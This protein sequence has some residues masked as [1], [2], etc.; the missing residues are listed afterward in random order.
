MASYIPERSRSKWNISYQ[1]PQVADGKIFYVKQE[2][3]ANEWFMQDAGNWTLV[4]ELRVPKWWEWEWVWFGV[5]TAW[6]PFMTTVQMLEPAD[7]DG[8]FRLRVSYYAYKAVIPQGAEDFYRRAS[9]VYFSVAFGI[10]AGFAISHGLISLIIAD[11]IRAQTSGFWLQEIMRWEFRFTP[12]EGD[13]LLTNIAI[14]E[15]LLH[16]QQSL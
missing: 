6:I 10:A 15:R 2:Q 13:G 5:W 1:N 8:N 11:I 3:F 4:S 14:M 9:T 16:N 12:G 7:E